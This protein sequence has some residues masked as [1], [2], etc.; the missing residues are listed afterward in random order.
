MDLL[1]PVLLELRKLAQRGG[2]RH[3]ARG[4]YRF[5]EVPV[6]GHDQ[7]MEAVLTV[8]P[9]AHLT[10][11]TI[12]SLHN[13]GLVNPSKI[14]VG[15]D[16][17]VR[18]QRPAF[19]DVARVPA[20]TED[21]TTC[22]GIPSTTI[23]RALLDCRGIVMGQRLVAAARTASPQCRRRRGVSPRSDP[24]PSLRALPDDERAVVRS[25]PS[26]F[27]NGDERHVCHTSRLGIR[28]IR[29]YSWLTPPAAR[30]RLGSVPRSGRGGRQRGW[31]RQ[32][33]RCR[34][35]SPRP[36]APWGRGPHRCCGRRGSRAGV[37]G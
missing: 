21:V 23:E 9:G 11:D 31:R 33:H 18:G 1:L 25:P 22:E 4:I 15:T 37:R 3:V 7:F 28:G 13:L 5:D 32:G 26:V 6:T 12:L 19:V 16:R 29:G 10:R 30:T 14:R 35:G 17:R 24:P 34:R 2:L 36:P 20:G 8:G 27:A